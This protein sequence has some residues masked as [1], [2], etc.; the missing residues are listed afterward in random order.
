MEIHH[1]TGL[2]Y[3]FLVSRRHHNIAAVN[4]VSHLLDCGT[5]LHS[6]ASMQISYPL[7]PTLPTLPT[8]PTVSTLLATSAFQHPAPSAIHH[9]CALTHLFWV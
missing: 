8:L 7:F 1:A 9:H 5:V 6:S 2:Q 3:I 4:P